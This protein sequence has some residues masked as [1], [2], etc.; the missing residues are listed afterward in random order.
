M[1][2]CDALFKNDRKSITLNYMSTLT[3]VIKIKIF[4]QTSV[5]NRIQMVIK[6]QNI[7]TAQKAVNS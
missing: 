5:K 3:T 7:H 1:A 6:F 4:V 2:N